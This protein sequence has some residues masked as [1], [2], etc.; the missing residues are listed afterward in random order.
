MN[1]NRSLSATKAQNILSTNC[2]GARV[3]SKR[4]GARVDGWVVVV[5]AL[6]LV[7]Q[8]SSSEPGKQGNNAKQI[9]LVFVRLSHG[10]GQ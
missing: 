10:I 7:N 8:S 2:P 9:G 1:D 6:C 4:A 3:Q 5:I